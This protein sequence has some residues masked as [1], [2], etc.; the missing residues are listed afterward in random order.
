M[1][2]ARAEIGR[3]DG[4][5][6]RLGEHRL[7]LLQPRHL[8]LDVIAAAMAQD[9]LAD[10]DRD[11][12]RVERALHREE[13]LTALVPLADADG[14][15]GRAVELL[16]QLHLD[17]R[18]L[19]L[20]HDDHL[21]AGRE[22]HQLFLAERPGAAD[23]EEPD[24]E[25]VGAHLVDAEI[26]ESLPHVE[27]ALA[28]GDDADLGVRP[29]G[30]DDPVELVR[31][32]EGEHGVAL[33]LLEALLLTEDRIVRPYVEAAR[34]HREALGD[35]DLHAL[36]RAVG[37]GGRFDVVLDELEPHPAPAEAAHR[38]AEEAVIEDLLHAR[39]MEDRDH[40]VDEMELALMRGG[41]GF[42]RVIVAHER[43]D[44]AMFR[45]AGEIGVAQRVTGAIDARPFPV[46]EAEDAVMAAFTAHFRL[47]RA[48]AARWPRAPR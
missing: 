12:V 36:E 37:R 27:I 10:R 16:A 29:A 1:R 41:R 28:G 3:A 4:D 40:H 42:G 5:I 21:E 35:D 15:I 9:A 38:V 26:V 47:L 23:L 34:R 39:R 18:A 44:A 48:P 7:R 11:V 6:L 17:E 32:D 22:R 30:G 20:D 14:L 25:I 8:R 31:L 19:L 45:G 43:E 33:V 2:T 13:P 46:P 24:A